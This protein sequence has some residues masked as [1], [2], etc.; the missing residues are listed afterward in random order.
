VDPAYLRLRLQ[1]G[2]GPEAKKSQAEDSLASQARV[3]S[4]SSRLQRPAG[5][6]AHP[7]QGGRKIG[8]SETAVRT[9]YDGVQRG[10][11]GITPHPWR[12]G[13]L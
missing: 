8:D 13:R 10:P 1:Q 9:C 6:S 7:L 5:D 11:N 4:R 3:E 12:A 2:R